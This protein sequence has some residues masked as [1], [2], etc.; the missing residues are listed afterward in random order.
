MVADH[1]LLIDDGMLVDQASPRDF[2]DE[3]GLRRHEG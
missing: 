3:P 1:V 2:F